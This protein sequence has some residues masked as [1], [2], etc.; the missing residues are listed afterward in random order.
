M[1]ASELTFGIEIET[2]ISTET[3]RR[4]RMTIGG[5]HHGIQVPYLQIGRAHV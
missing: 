1:N 5:Y 2:T 3:V 4:E